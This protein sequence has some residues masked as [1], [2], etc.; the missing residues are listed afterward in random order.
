[1]QQEQKKTGYKKVY[2]NQFVLSRHYQSVTAVSVDEYRIR[3]SLK[4]ILV[5]S[6]G[7]HFITSSISYFV[8]DMVY[9]YIF[10]NEVINYLRS[11]RNSILLLNITKTK[12]CSVAQTPRAR[13]KNGTR[14]IAG[15]KISMLR[16]ELFTLT[17][18]LVPKVLLRY[19][20]AAPFCRV[21]APIYT[22][23]KALVLR[24]EI[25]VLHLHTIVLELSGLS[26]SSN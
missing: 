21:D 9:I 20:N 11:Y 17:E 7:S 4:V 8:M 12:S 14:K 1:M 16:R 26:L 2:G 23:I 3:Y 6:F 22:H 25:F 13:K 15:R 24:Q 18:L 10:Y 5:N 19:F